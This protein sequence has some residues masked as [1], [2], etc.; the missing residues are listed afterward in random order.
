MKKEKKI[1]CV[2]YKGELPSIRVGK[3]MD[4]A[5]YLIRHNPKDILAPLQ[6]CKIS[7]V[8]NQKP[9]MN[10]EIKVR[11][12]MKKE[13]SLPNASYDT[14]TIKELMSGRY[15][16]EKYENW[17]Q[18]TGLSDKNGKEIYE[19]DIVKLFDYPWSR[20]GMPYTVEWDNEMRGFNPFCINTEKYGCS[21]ANEWTE[22]I[23]NIYENKDLTKEQ[24]AIKKIKSLEDVLLAIKPKEKNPEKSA[25]YHHYLIKIVEKWQFNKPFQE[26][27]QKMKEAI[28]DLILKN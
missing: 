1:V 22:I 19:G 4:K 23:G 18:S 6:L 25:E 28:A 5:G 16:F 24:K 17:G 15:D 3:E 2:D 21:S 9:K 10:K 8:I 11:A 26:Q 14:F 12:F 20:S 7:S 27:N 13:F